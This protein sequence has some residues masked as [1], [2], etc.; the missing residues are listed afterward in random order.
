MPTHELG[1]ACDDEEDEAEREEE[2]PQDAP[3]DRWPA[4]RRAAVPVPVALGQLVSDDAEHGSEHGGDR[5]LGRCQLH[6]SLRDPVVHFRRPVTG[7][8]I[9]SYPLVE[10]PAT[11]GRAHGRGPEH[12]EQQCGGGGFRSWATSRPRFADVVP[13]EPPAASHTGCRPP[14][15]PAR[16]SVRT[17]WQMAIPPARGSSTRRHV[18]PPVSRR[19]SAHADASTRIIGRGSSA[20]LRGRCS[21][22]PCTND[23]PPPHRFRGRHRTS[24]GPCVSASARTFGSG[25]ACPRSTDPRSVGP[26]WITAPGMGPTRPSRV[27]SSHACGDGG[28]RTLTGGG[29]SA[30]PLPIG[31]R[32]RSTAARDA[33]L[34]RTRGPYRDAVDAP[35][36]PQVGPIAGPPAGGICGPPAGRR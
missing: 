14:R 30:L 20:A 9:A 35:R 18:G 21:C 2:E 24:W 34:R 10:V 6:L 3:G 19:N 26:A 36:P 28:S 1:A 31:L 11:A 4:P 27:G 29:L 22:V 13:T 15:A 17:G 25:A 23:A 7:R 32:P 12:P 8:T 33:A 5:R 16:S